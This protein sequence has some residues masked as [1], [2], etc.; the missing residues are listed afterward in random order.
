MPSRS[1]GRG[2]S[3]IIIRPNRDMVVVRLRKYAGARTGDATLKD[4]LA[5]LMEA[6]PPKGASTP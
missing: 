3:T 1:A 2:Q 5:L 4:G 6:V